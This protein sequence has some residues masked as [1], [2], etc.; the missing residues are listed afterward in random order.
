MAAGMS[1]AHQLRQARPWGQHFPEPLFDGEFTLVQQR[2]VGKKHL[3]MTLAKDPQGQD[4]IDAIAFNIDPQEWP[5]PQAKKNQSR[6]PAGR[7]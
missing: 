2:L 6:L 7:Q 3:K 5:D 4:L 1:L